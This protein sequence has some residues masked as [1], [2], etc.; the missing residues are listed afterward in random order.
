MIF[1]ADSLLPSWPI[2]PCRSSL[3]ERVIYAARKNRRL[4]SSL[5][6]LALGVGEAILVLCAGVALLTRCS[7][8]NYNTYVIT[9]FEKWLPSGRSIVRVYRSTL[10][11]AYFGDSEILEALGEP[12]ITKRQFIFLEKRDQ[13]IRELYA[14]D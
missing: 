3:L 4:S 10:L 12:S 1:L 6:R 8:E 13:A 14:P 11:M 7:Q 9:Y 2:V 5:V